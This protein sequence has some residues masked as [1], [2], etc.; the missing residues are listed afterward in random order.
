M[1]TKVSLIMDTKKICHTHTSGDKLNEML[2]GDNLN[3]SPIYLKIKKNRQSSS[4]DVA[5]RV[6]MLNPSTL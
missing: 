6:L 4:D 3:E 2:E 1:D 5:S